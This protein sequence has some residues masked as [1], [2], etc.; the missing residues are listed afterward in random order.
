MRPCKITIVIGLAILIILSAAA[1]NVS[2]AG[3]PIG[4]NREKTLDDTLVLVTGF[5]PFDQY[6][7]N[8]AQLIAEN[9]D[10]EEIDGAH[11]IGITVPVDFNDSVAVVTQAIEQ[12]NPDIVIS[13]GLEAR[14]HTI[15]IE[16]IGLNLKRLPAD[17]VE[18]FRYRR[19]DPCGPFV[20]LSSIPN[21]CITKAIRNAGIPARQS[22]YAG[23]YICNALLYGVLSYIEDNDSSMKVGFIH[24]PLLSSQDPNRGMELDTMINAVKIAIRESL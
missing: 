23:T 4:G 16:K 10:G 2:L 22:F 17:E 7:V 1:S 13:I 9:L 19:I 5:E 18:I 21:R 20:R 3:S 15:H 11:I 12:Y 8:P 14:I 6:D 24:V